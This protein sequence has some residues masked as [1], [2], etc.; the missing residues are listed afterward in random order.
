MKTIIGNSIFFAGV[1]FGLVCLFFACFPAWGVFLPDGEVF[2]IAFA[3]GAVTYANISDEIIANI[4][5]WHGT[6]D[7]QFSN[8]DNLFNLL[9]DNGTQWSVPEEMLSNLTDH[10]NELADLIPKCRSNRASTLDRNMRN[11]L[12]KST[13]GFCLTQI[14]AW[15]YTQHYAG[16]LTVEDVHALGFFLPGETGGFH[17]RKEATDAL[18]EVKVKVINEDFIHVVVDQAAGENAALVNHGWPQGVTMAVI[19]IRSVDGNTEVYNK[20]TTHLHNKIEMPKGS[21]GKQFA[22]KAAFLRHV[23]DA[24]TFG[25]APTFSMP[26]STDDLVEALDRQHHEDF[27][28]QLREVERH[29]QE[30]EELKKTKS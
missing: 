18:A 10:R 30:V 24:P 16:V 19:V 26:L 17:S 1:V 4:R 27:E 7:E 29:R 21:R 22:I 2:T 5:R 8:I 6:I 25:P 28:A 11:G 15:V 20:T 9:K 12:L 13:V 23:D 14:K 3:M